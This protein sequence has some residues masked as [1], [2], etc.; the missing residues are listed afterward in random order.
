VVELSAPLGKVELTA[1]DRKGAGSVVVEVRSGELAQAAIKL[2]A[3]GG[4]P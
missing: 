1:R 3:P 2:A 4:R